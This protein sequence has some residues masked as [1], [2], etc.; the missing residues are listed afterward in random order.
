MNSHHCTT[1]AVSIVNL[2][3]L[4]ANPIPNFGFPQGYHKL[5]VGNKIFGVGIVSIVVMFTLISIGD[6]PPVQN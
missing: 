2:V 3:A 5:I 6:G 1:E 4:M